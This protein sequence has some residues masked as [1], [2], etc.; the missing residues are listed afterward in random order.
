[1]KNEN[2][3]Q[4]RYHTKTLTL[5]TT[6]ATICTGFTKLDAQEVS[7]QLKGNMNQSV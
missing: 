3:I 7:N 2:K 6:T 5:W 4:R 1:M